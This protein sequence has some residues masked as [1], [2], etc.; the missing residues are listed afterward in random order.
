MRPADL[1]PDGPLGEAPG[2]RIARPSPP[3]SPAVSL[4]SFAGVVRRVRDGARDVAVLDGVSFEID[5]GAVVGLYGARRSGKS[6]LLRL[7]AAIEPPDEGTVRFEGRDVTRL[8]AGDR[9]RLLRGS[10]ALLAAADWLPGP[11]ET[12]LD[13]VAVSAGGDGLTLRDARRRAHAALDRVGVTALGGAEPVASLSQRERSLV[14]LARALVRSP[15]LLLVDEPAPMPSIGDR[16][17]FCALLRTLARERGMALLIASEEM[18][19]LQ[20][21]DVLMLISSGE[22]CSTEESA[23]VVSLPRRRA[24]GRPRP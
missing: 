15:R 10:V 19:T 1:S 3:P 4:L 5:P 9:A 6:T 13:H 23:T 21:V 12:V 8:S 7:C 2:Q 24:A 18:A 11:G 17:R 14:M 20:G 16:E 22:L